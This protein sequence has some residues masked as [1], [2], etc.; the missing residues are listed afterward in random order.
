MIVE[1]QQNQQRYSNSDGVYSISAQSEAL[2]GFTIPPLTIS[3]IGK[4]LELEAGLHPTIKGLIIWIEDWD[5]YIAS[6]ELISDLTESLSMNPHYTYKEHSKVLGAIMGKSIPIIKITTSSILSEIEKQ[7]NK[8]KFAGVKDVVWNIDSLNT[9]DI[10]IL[11]GQI[12]WTLSP[13]PKPLDTF[14]T[15]DLNLSGDYSITT[16]PI[17][18][19]DENAKIPEDVLASNLK[20]I[21]DRLTLLRT[22]FNAIKQLFY[23]GIQS[24]NVTTRHTIL[25]TADEGDDINVQ[26]VTKDTTMIS[27]QSLPQNQL[28]D[29]QSESVSNL[30]TKVDT[31]STNLTQKIN[32]TEST[33]RSAQAGDLAA[34]TSLN[35]QLSDS[36][37]FIQK[38]REKLKA[39]NP[40][41]DI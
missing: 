30:S 7:K 29:K 11:L 17:T 35:A 13:S 20:L 36:K 3:P 16:L 27:N 18:P 24:S 14:T 37:T 23:F 34:Q 4:D 2:G 5:R 9:K 33:I 19:L 26:V 15:F 28:A 32:Q 12:N 22:D 39:A 41:L 21:D 25:A 40:N 31:T 10:T 8:I 6:S 38:L 1:V